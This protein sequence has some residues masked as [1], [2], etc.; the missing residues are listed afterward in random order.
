M[1]WLN[2]IFGNTKLHI[3]LS[4]FLDQYG[5]SGLEQAIQL[6]ENMN[7]EYIW[8]TRES[9]YKIKIYDIYYLEIK[10]HTITVHTRHN[11][12][13][14]Y[15]SL[16]QESKFL[17]PYGFIKC[18]QSCIVSIDKI[19][20]VCNNTIILNNDQQLHVSQGHIA[21]VLIACS[22]NAKHIRLK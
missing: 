4:T 14:K 2:N 16:K 21:K 9:I 17:A 10:G 13:R 3:K 7:L 6:Y 19:I 5:I 11:T 8:K 1:N 15:G 20:A 12:Y 22:H 18:N